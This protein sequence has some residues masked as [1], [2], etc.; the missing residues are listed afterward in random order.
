MAVYKGGDGI[1]RKNDF[2]Q[3]NHLVRFKQRI[4]DL[5]TPVWPLTDRLV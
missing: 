5:S 3:Q 1:Y 4:N 2:A